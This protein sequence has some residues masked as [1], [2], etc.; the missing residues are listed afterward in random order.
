MD[1]IGLAKTTLSL[2][3]FLLKGRRLTNKGRRE[4]VFRREK[5]ARVKSQFP[6]VR[7]GF[8]FVGNII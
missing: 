2:L 4:E 1:S 8:G 7:K 3:Y 6:R 5:G